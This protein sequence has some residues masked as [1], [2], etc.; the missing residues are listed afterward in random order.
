M[1]AICTPGAPPPVPVTVPVAVN[2]APSVPST[3]RAKSPCSTTRVVVPLPGVPLLP[4]TVSIATKPVGVVR[5]A[6]WPLG[7][8]SISQVS[9]SPTCTPAGLLHVMVVPNATTSVVLEPR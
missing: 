3:T 5:V 9:R 1:P 8:F 4:L 7:L 6:S 2:E